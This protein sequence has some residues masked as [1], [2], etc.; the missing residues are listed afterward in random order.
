MI[1]YSTVPV[2]PA[3]PDDLRHVADVIT[4]AFDSLAPTRW[5][6]P[7]DTRRRRVFKSGLHGPAPARRHDRDDQ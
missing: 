4:V 1:D 2:V 6:V 7:D 5:L 3:G